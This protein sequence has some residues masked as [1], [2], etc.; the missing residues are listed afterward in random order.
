MNEVATKQEVAAEVTAPVD[1]SMAIVQIIE[2]AAMNPNVDIE[3]MERLLQMQMTIMEKSA[4]SEF[5]V[6][7][8]KVQEEMR[9]IS[10]DATNTQTRSKYA[11]YANLDKALRPI[12]AKHGFSLSFG[13]D[14]GA[15]E[16]HVRV[17]CDVIHTSGHE[18]R[19]SLDMPAD[20]KGAKGGDVMTKTH[21]T[22]SAA[23]Y[24]R[25]GLLK[26]IFNISEGD[27]DGNAASGATRI[28]DL[29][30]E[31]LIAL[32]QET[33]TNTQSALAHFYGADGPKSLDE[34]TI[35][36]PYPYGLLMN[37]LRD[38]KKKLAAKKEAAE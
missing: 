34:L 25:R 14:D 18:K 17:V 4:K 15:P 31:D 36:G 9:P 8:N 1:Q 3:K 27:D 13:T 19:Y 2:R 11:T 10:Q 6:A 20:G 5:A 26:M 12:Y 24:A 35:R 21:A 38:K 30:K 37:G 32:L 23:T 16:N 33:D 7:M 22:M 28:D 29:T